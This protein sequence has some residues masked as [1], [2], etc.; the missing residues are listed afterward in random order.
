[1]REEGFLCLFLLLP[2]SPSVSHCLADK[3]MSLSFFVTVALEPA[4]VPPS[5]WA[6]K[7]QHRTALWFHTE[8]T[9]Q[10]PRCIFGK[11]ESPIFLALMMHIQSSPE[12]LCQRLIKTGRDQGFCVVLILYCPTQAKGQESTGQK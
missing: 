1:M 11:N 2:L 6:F 7:L 9:T 12:Q 5:L 8:K 3:Q 4:V 10:L